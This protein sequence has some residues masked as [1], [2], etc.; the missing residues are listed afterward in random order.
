MSS[1][2]RK[3]NGR[4]RVRAIG[5]GWF[6]KASNWN[7]ARPLDPLPCATGVGH[8]DFPLFFFL[9]KGG[10]K[11]VLVRMDRIHPSVSQTEYPSFRTYPLPMGSISDDQD[12]YDTIPFSIHAID[13]PKRNPS[14]SIPLPSSSHDGRPTCG[15]SSCM[16]EVRQNS[17]KK[18]R[19]LS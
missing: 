2:I 13:E 19:M 17:K 11:R 8:R 4:A 1:A 15:G 12:R 9:R 10:G 6:W 18:R 7:Q 5:V 16:Q 14:H 3:R